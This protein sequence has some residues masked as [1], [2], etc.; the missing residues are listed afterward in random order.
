[1]IAIV[2]GKTTI[3]DGKMTGDFNVC[4]YCGAKCI[5]GNHDTNSYT[6]ECG[7][8]MVW[9]G[10]RQYGIECVHRQVDMLEKER[11]HWYFE[12]NFLHDAGDKFL[13]PVNRVTANH[14]HG[15]SVQPKYLDRLSNAQLDFEK[16]MEKQ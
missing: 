10:V 6:Y 12:Y 16:A 2:G 13:C 5:G 9:T 8:H 15:N 4:R 14:R 3:G 7:T 11:D 1:M